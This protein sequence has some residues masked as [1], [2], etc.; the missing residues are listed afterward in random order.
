MKKK[1]P[2]DNLDSIAV[3]FEKMTNDYVFMKEKFAD[4]NF[5]DIDKVIINFKECH[6]AICPNG[7]LIAIC[8]KKGFLDIT[9]GSKINKYIIV[10]YQNA[11]RKYLIPI[12]WNYKERYVINL[13]FNEK[14]QLYAICNDGSIL[15]IDILTQR[16]VQ[17]KSSDFFKNQQIEKAK[18]IDNG[19]IAL[20]HDGNFVYAKDIKDPVPKLIFPMESLLHF[21]NNIKFLSIPPSKSKSK[22][23]E[24]LITNEKGDGV[25]HIEEPEE[26]N[27]FNM[28]PV[29]DRPGVMKC[30]GASILIKDKIEPYY[31]NMEENKEPEAPEPGKQYEKLGRIA[32]LAISPKKDQLA[33]YD[34]RGVVFFFYS[35]FEE[36]GKRKKVI[37]ELD[38]ESSSEDLTEQQKIINFEDGCQF[39]YCGEDAVALCGY[40]F[41]FIINSLS[42][43]K[44]FKIIENEKNYQL[45]GPALCKCISEVDG[46]R[47]LTNEGIFF[48][49][50]VAK[51]LVEICDPFS[52]ASSK[53]LLKAYN[54][55]LNKDTNSEKLIRDIKD[56]LSNAIYNLEIGAANIFWTKSE[57]DQEK[58][59][60]QLFLL[61][62]A[63]HAKFFVKK[64]IFN[65]DKF[66]QICKDIRV[67]NNLRNHSFKPKFITYNEYK[68]MES[69]RDLIHKIIRSLNFGFAFKIAQY[70]EEDIKYIYEK[71]CIAC[72]KRN[73]GLLDAEEETKIFEQLND[74]LKNVKNFSYINL[75]KKCFK[76]HRDV[77]GLK[78]L[79]NEKSIL[80]KLPKF[81]DKEEWDKVLEL[82]ENIYDVFIIMSIFE[83]IFKKT[84]LSNFIELVVKYSKLKPFVIEFLKKNAPK[85]INEY[86]ENLK[87]P[88]EMFFYALEQYFQSSKYEDRKKYIEIAREN[89]KLIDNMINPN[90][91]HKFYKSYLDSL[92]YNL[93]VK[94]DCLNLDSIV[95][96]KPDDT[97]FD[98]SMYDIYK[99]GVR[100]GK[101]SWVESQNKYF[102]FSP[103]GMAIMNAIAH[104]EM[105]K[106]S[107]IDVLV[108]RTHNNIKKINLTYL[109]LFQIACTF[110]QNDLAAKYSTFLTEPIFFEY[111]LD[112][113]KQIEKYEEALEAIITNKNI[114]NVSEL[115]KEIASKKPKLLR[116][117]KELAEKHKVILDLE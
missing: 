91:D 59:E 34:D 92:D 10:M 2:L 25:I 28:L 53:K 33:I 87:T 57:D 55:S 114:E 24:L 31:L 8:K 22:K 90:F 4:Y 51:E 44:V 30:N 83:K 3:N 100:A 78:F 43:K 76:Y 98:L 14:E 96:P 95:I 6:V 38:E 35:N 80:T 101:S 85:S 19:F 32:A 71:Y 48:I 106:L 37:I 70:L 72:I 79:D 116:K 9:R 102:N 16:V 65:F 21:S 18:L 115:V 47:Y 7:G 81:I 40:R 41:I 45:F 84:T 66:Y 5:D 97:S 23:L 73:T 60:A 112:M 74:K 61:E 69:S 20:T 110:K 50:R 11:K 109:N 93:K 62:A 27:Q 49:S 89:E 86:M 29:E 56:N 46:I 68:S 58:K 67:I 52:N 36:G 12:D 99:F 13:E 82:T 94:V 117:A 1:S 105:N 88:E 15:K 103:E 42:T 26:Q 111:K 113:L 77:I 17:K 54:N 107:A 39:L 64:E 104:G 108:E 63:Q 75:A